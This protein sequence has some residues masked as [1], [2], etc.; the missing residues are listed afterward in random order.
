MERIGLPAFRVTRTCAQGLGLAQALHLDTAT[1][2]RNVADA[3]ALTGVQAYAAAATCKLQAGSRGP[4][5]MQG[6]ALWSEPC[7]GASNIHDLDGAIVACSCQEAARSAVSQGTHGLAEARCGGVL[8]QGGILV[9]L[10]CIR[11]KCSTVCLRLEAHGQCTDSAL[12]YC[13]LRS[14][15]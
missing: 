15:P 1:A 9:Y 12:L 7:L 5:T 4:D 2:G 14:P 6:R 13:R 3:A 8:R 10:H 11:S